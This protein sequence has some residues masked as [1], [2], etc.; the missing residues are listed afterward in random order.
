MILISALLIFSRDHSLSPKEREYI[1][2]FDDGTAAQDHLIKENDH[3]S[4]DCQNFFKVIR[5]TE[6]GSMVLI[7]TKEA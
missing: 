4:T 3:V 2:F 7:K 1:G 6:D 5:I